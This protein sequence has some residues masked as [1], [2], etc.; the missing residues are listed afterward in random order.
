MTEK[1]FNFKDKNTL[2]ILLSTILLVVLFLSTIQ[3]GSIGDIVSGE[4]KEVKLPEVKVT[5]LTVDCE[6]CIEMDGVVEAISSDPVTLVTERVE[7]FSDEG[8]KLLEKYEITQVPNIIIDGQLSPELITNFGEFLQDNGKV[9]TFKNLPAPYVDTQTEKIVGEVSV[10]SIVDKTCTICQEINPLL[11]QLENI[12]IFISDKKELNHD[13]DEAKE[14]IEKYDI[15]VIP[16]LIMSKEARQY[17]DLIE[18]WADVGIIDA[19]GSFVLTNILPPYKEVSTGN[20]VGKVKLS[21]LFDSDCDECYKPEEFHIPILEN[22]GIYI[23]SQ[24]KIGLTTAKGKEL[25]EKYS[26]TKIPTVILTGDTDS[27]KAFTSVWDSVGTIED[28]GAYVFNGFHIVNGPYKDL[29]TNEVIIPET[30][31]PNAQAAAQVAS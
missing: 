16:T 14:L 24:E 19:D 4:K 10:V 31:D 3:L 8:K 12:G 5:L 1:K 6:K 20:L 17:P 29:E 28:D 23:D 21:I 30:P 25:I 13:S 2:L 7:A 11:G 18:A 22:L 9:F 27:Y 15:K 26:I